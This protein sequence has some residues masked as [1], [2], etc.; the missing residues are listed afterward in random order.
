MLYW[1]V[2][3]LV[4]ALVSGL[5]GFTNIAVGAAEIAKFLFLIF[6]AL[7]IVSFIASLVTREPPRA[8]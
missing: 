1:T 8:P 2:T 7:F 3:F 5:L 6:L 4:V